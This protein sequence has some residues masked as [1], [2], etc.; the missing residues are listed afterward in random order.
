[1]APYKIGVV[2]G[3]VNT[4]E[5][6]KADYLKK[7]ETPDDAT[8]LRMLFKDRLDLIVIDKYVAIHNLK[9][10]PT[11]EGD[12]SSVEFLKPPLITQPIYCMFSRAKQDFEQKVADF[13]RGLKAITEDGTVRNIMIKNGFLVE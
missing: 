10:S 3:Y 11:L 8:S 13:N 5:F 6:D 4:P 1:M 9:N 12:F 7:M 2:R